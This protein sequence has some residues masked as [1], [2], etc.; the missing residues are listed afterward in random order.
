MINE[1]DWPIIDDYE[2]LIGGGS[3][4]VSNGFTGA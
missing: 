4:G 3:G 1:E 2:S